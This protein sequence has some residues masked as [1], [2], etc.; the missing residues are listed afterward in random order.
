MLPVVPMFHANA[1]G[2]P[3]GAVD[4]RREAGDA[5]ART[6]IRRAW[7]T[8]S[9]RER[10]TLTGG[11]PTIWMGVLQDLEANPGTFDLLEPSA[12]CTSAA[13]RCRESLIDAFERTYGLRILQAWGM[14]ETGAARHRGAPAAAR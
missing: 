2:M 9:S 1:W 11:V 13:P 5:R 4:G 10:V 12:R 8:C 3:F 7:S 6:S 14:T